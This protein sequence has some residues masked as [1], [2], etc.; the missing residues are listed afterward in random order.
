M[1]FKTKTIQALEGTLQDLESEKSRIETMIEQARTSLVEAKK[2]K[3]FLEI[4]K[5]EVTKIVLIP[6]V[7]AKNYAQCMHISIDEHGLG[8]CEEEEIADHCEACGKPLCTEHKTRY[9]FF[10]GI[11]NRDCCDACSEL[12]QENL[13]AIR[14]LRL[15]LNRI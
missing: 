5:P 12:E 3:S 9:I 10:D 7:I 2:P 14:K 8:V 15:E 4:E 13:A 1:D 11:Q 6:Q